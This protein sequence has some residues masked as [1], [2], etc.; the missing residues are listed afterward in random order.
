[1][2][3]PT[4]KMISRTI[5]PTERIKVKGSPKDHGCNT[6]KGEMGRLIKVC[7]QQDGKTQREMQLAKKLV[8]RPSARQQ[9]NTSVYSWLEARVCEGYPPLQ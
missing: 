8:K 7:V 2:T 1:M 3:K 9:R 6:M 5:E 4:K